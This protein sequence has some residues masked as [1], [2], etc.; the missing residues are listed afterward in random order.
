VPLVEGVRRRAGEGARAPGPARDGDDAFSC[1]TET[2]RSARDVIIPT[3]VFCATPGCTQQL[4]LGPWFT[5]ES[6][7]TNVE[8]TSDVDVS[9]TWLSLG[10]GIGFF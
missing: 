3:S 1:A 9:G 5:D 8:G 4:E 6:G 10:V 7:R 2:E